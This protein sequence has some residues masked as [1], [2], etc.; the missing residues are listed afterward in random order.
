[1]QIYSSTTIDEG[2][3]TERTFRVVRHRDRGS[4]EV[5]GRRGE[6]G[7]ERRQTF[8]RLATAIGAMVEWAEDERLASAQR[9][10]EKAA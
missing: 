8:Y 6:Q 9:H 7:W 10:V 2:H 4:W 5:Q 1:M 3:P